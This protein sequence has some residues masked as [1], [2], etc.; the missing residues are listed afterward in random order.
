MNKLHRQMEIDMHL[1]NF[2]E[3][4]RQVY[5]DA[6]CKFEA[7]FGG[8]V[9]EAGVEDIRAYLHHMVECNLS[10]SSLKHAYS[11]LKLMTEVTLGKTW[12][13]RRIPKARKKKRLPVIL[14]Q[15]EV[16][17]IIAAASSLK[18]QA[19]FTTIY[20]AGLRTSE[21]AQL[22]LSDIDSVGMRIRV[23]QGKGNKDRFTLLADTTLDLLRTYWR[24]RRPPEWLFTPDNTVDRPISERS[25]QGA[26]LKALRSTSIQK[27]ATPRSLRHAGACPEPV[28]GPPTYMR[29]GTTSRR[30]RRSWG[31][32]HHSRLSPPLQK[33][34]G[35]RQESDRQLVL[36]PSGQ[37][38]K[39]VM[40]AFPTLADVFLRFGQAYRDLYADRMPG[41]HLKTMR[42]IETCRTPAQGGHLYECDQCHRQHLVFH[43]C[44]NRHCPTCQFLP[45]ER[46]VQ[47][48]QRDLLP[49][50]Y[51]HVVF[52]IPS[53]LHDLFRQNQR[54]CYG[55]LF[56]AASET[57]LTLSE[58]TQ[59]LGA[60]IGFVAV[61]HTW[62]QRLAYHPHIHCIVTGG[63]L[64]VDQQRWVRA[65]PT[66]FIHVHVLAALFRGKLL[67]CLRD[68]VDRG[69]L[70][71]DSPIET[72]RL[73]GKLYTRN[74]NVD[75]REP[76][77]G[78]RHVVEYLG[79]YTH[80]VAISNHRI[81]GIDNK[82]VVFR[83]RDPDDAS[84]TRIARLPAHEFIRRFL[85]HVLPAGFVK[86][87]HYGIL[88]NRVR[89]VLVARARVLL[90]VTTDPVQ[91]TQSWRELLEAL[92]GA[93]PF[94]CPY[95]K[96][97]N[98]VLVAELQPQRAPP[99]ESLARS[100]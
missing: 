18:Y 74:W 7:H 20:S 39:G 40:S 12:E 78:P 34:S 87:R 68:A 53:E 5:L 51:F 57:L 50:P 85:Q 100:A 44:R 11:A 69:D 73:L 65:N 55:L 45:R 95:C 26:F 80:R 89:K 66:F 62:T 3:C 64:S 56:Q 33:A 16:E 35:K 9:D 72:R 75:C 70:R 58:D 41:S 84:K 94:S 96:K 42:A 60:R 54:C 28:E 19:I 29:P 8:S 17:A 61:L 36:I 6:I 49:I 92:T 27:P 90:V 25:I 4:T 47:S 13:A 88:A 97:G 59:H 2:S 38:G 14:S 46:W 82:E 93:D 1:G 31:N 99:P 67:A 43:S 32:Q 91:K 77:A 15:A 24:T 30:S 86:I 22:K 23:D 48:R 76:F 98:L 83:Y 37:T 52:T 63:G 71:V 10:E 81:T 79:R 21:A